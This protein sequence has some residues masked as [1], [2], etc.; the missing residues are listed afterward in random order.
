MSCRYTWKAT[1]PT[2]GASARWP[3]G[4]GMPGMGI[5]YSEPLMIQLHELLTAIAEG[6]AAIPSFYDG[7]RVD[8]ICEAIARSSDTGR[9]EKT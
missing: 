1:R 7:W 5:G 3:P 9:W 8:C 2:C 6:T 4:S